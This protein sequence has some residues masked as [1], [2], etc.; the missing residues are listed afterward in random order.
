MLGAAQ[1]LAYPVINCASANDPAA[2][3][4]LAAALPFAQR[5]AAIRFFQRALPASAV[6]YG[7]DHAETLAITRALV[8]LT[9]GQPELGNCSGLPP[10]DG[11]R[12]L[13]GLVICGYCGKLGSK[14]D[15]KACARCRRTFYC[16]RECQVA[17]WKAGHKLACTVT[18]T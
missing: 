2:Q 7:L 10:P 5:Q 15:I 6:L 4:A 14:D 12:L 18:Q 17:A 9:S 16:T 11:D 8:A 1:A 13:S 3:F